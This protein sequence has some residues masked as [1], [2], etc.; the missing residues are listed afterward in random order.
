MRYFIFFLFIFPISVS[1]G[2]SLDGVI[3]S[4][5]EDWSIF[6][7]TPVGAPSEQCSLYQNVISSDRKE[8]GLSIAISK[9]ADGE[10]R[11]LKILAPLGILLSNGLG[12][13]IDGNDMGRAQFT[14]C[15]P[16]GCSA[17]VIMDDDM[18]SRFR[19][20]EQ[21]TFVVFVTPEEGIGVPISLAGFSSGYDS[22]P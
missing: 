3:Q 1:F 6:C 5:H 22:L 9:T 4:V 11:I 10:A 2:Q 14:R 12:L 15:I 17:E 19:S 8:M 20:G 16:D 7:D 13:H 18:L 21:A